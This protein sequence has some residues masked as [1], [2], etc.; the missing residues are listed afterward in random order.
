MLFLTSQ[1]NIVKQ[2]T[3]AH[4]E[5]LRKMNVKGDDQLNA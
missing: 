5:S 3:Q 1:S 2:A 4:S